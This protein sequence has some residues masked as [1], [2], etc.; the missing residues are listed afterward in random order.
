L[1]LALFVP[2]YIYRFVGDISEYLMLQYENLRAFLDV[3]RLDKNQKLKEIISI[4]VQGQ[5]EAASATLSRLEKAMKDI[6]I[7]QQQTVSGESRSMPVPSHWNILIPHDGYRNI[8][9]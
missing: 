6:S 9:S 7:E 8:N 5:M 4:E 2:E 3:L 1:A